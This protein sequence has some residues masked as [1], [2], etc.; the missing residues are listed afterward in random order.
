MANVSSPNGIKTNGVP[1]PQELRCFIEIEMLG[2]VNRVV[3]SSST[4]RKFGRINL[5]LTSEEESRDFATKFHQ[6]CKDGSISKD[7]MFRLIERQVTVDL[8]N[9]GNAP[10]GF[11]SGAAPAKANT[12]SWRSLFGRGEVA[13]APARTRNA[14]AG[15]IVDPNLPPP[16]FPKVKTGSRRLRHDEPFVISGRVEGSEILISTEAATSLDGRWVVFGKVADQDSENIVKRIKRYSASTQ[17]KVFVASSGVGTV[18]G[19]PDVSPSADSTVSSGQ[20]VAT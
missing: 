17:N 4:T 18:S 12:G 5:I 11:S 13:S 20:V 10:T 19:N 3:Q 2:G 6:A 15:G 1:A 8:T 14:A 9:S 7:A 16:F